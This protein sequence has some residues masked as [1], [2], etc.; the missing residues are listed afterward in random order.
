[1]VHPCGK[2]HALFAIAPGPLR[3][4]ILFSFWRSTW[5]EI[6]QQ[7]ISVTEGAC[8]QRANCPT[9]AHEQYVSPLLVEDNVDNV[10]PNTR[11]RAHP[12]VPM[13]TLTEPLCLPKGGLCLFRCGFMRGWVA[14]LEAGQGSP[15]T[16]TVS[17]APTVLFHLQMRLQRSVTAASCS[18]NRFPNR[19]YR[20]LTLFPVASHS[21]LLGPHNQGQGWFING[22]IIMP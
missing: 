1:M 13:G 18:L 17:Y 3:S 4:C 14:G 20:R 2:R 7:C 6:Q 19:I 15:P 5:M 12:G 22:L 9:G 11:T 8:E 21:C 10:L 16:V